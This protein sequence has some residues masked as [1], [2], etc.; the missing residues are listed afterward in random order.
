MREEFGIGEKGLVCLG[1]FK[2]VRAVYDWNGLK[3]ELDETHYDFGTSYE[4]ECE[5]LEPEKTKKLLGELLKKNGIS[6]SY[7]EVSKFAIFRSGKLP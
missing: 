7:S 3:L 6:Y 4:L 5:S 1:G 2:N